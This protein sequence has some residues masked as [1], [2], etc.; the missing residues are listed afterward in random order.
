L[1]LWPEFFKFDTRG[2]WS[3]ILD[4]PRTAPE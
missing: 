2:P 3:K 4:P 1:A